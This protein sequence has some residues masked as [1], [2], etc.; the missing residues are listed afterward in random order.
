MSIVTNTGVT[1]TNA[2]Y[3]LKLT[4]ANPIN[5]DGYLIITV[6]SSITF[7]VSSLAISACFVGCATGYGTFTSPTTTTIEISN[8]FS[9]STSAILPG[10]LIWI[11]IS[12]WTN[13]PSATPATFTITSYEA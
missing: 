9:Y 1:Q 2:V 5:P 12:G 4:L 6:P 11:Y 3:S 7:S 8:F 10:S 13:P